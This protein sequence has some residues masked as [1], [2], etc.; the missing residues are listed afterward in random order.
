MSTWMRSWICAVLMCTAVAGCGV[1]KSDDPL[2]TK[3][4]ELKD[5][6]QTARLSDLT[7]FAWDEVHL[8][9]EYTRREAIEQI[10]G[11]PVI[12]AD[13]HEAGSLL[14]FEDHGKVVKTVTVG[15]DYLRAD[16]YTFGSDVLVKPWG[17]GAVRLIPPG[18]DGPQTG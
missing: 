10:V 11:A 16:G 4:S 14:V 17:N 18:A 15:G 12:S 6:G 13:R 8:F 5:S 1:V 7:D 2:E 9:N 3:L